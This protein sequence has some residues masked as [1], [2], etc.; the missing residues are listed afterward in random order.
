M[1]EESVSTSAL[2]AGNDPPI[3][4]RGSNNVPEST[5]MQ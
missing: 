3:G 4:L 5:A 1:I 2:K